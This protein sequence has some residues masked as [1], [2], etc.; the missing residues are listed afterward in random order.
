MRKLKQLFYNAGGF[1][2]VLCAAGIVL[3]LSEFGK[4]SALGKV[5]AIVCVV[6]LLFGLAYAFSGYVK[7]SAKLYKIFIVL[8]SVSSLLSLANFFE[9]V[10]NKNALKGFGIAILV[11]HLAIT[12]LA[13]VL[14]FVKDL[15]RKKSSNISYVLI[16]INVLIFMSSLI[17][18]LDYIIVALGNLVLACVVAVFIASKYV[19]KASRGRD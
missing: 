15:G 11:G 4:L 6:G 10:S 18:N 16:G 5:D 12:V 3:R 2:I 7:T 13:F 14:A 8:Y 9:S 19:D 1:I 17:G